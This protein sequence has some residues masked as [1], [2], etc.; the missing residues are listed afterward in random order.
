MRLLNDWHIAEKKL[1]V[2]ESVMVYLVYVVLKLKGQV[3]SSLLITL[4]PK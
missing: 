3:K 2:S 4:R 1:V